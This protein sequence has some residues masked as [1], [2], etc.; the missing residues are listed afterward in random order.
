MSTE[1][2]A[3][4]VRKSFDQQGVTKTL[5]LEIDSLSSGE[6]VLS[7]P[8]NEA[9]TQQHGF[10]HAG[11]V[12]TGL[13]NACGFAAFSQMPAESEVLTVEFKTNLIAPAKGERFLFKA[14]TVK[15]G[16]TLSFVEAKAF[17]VNEGEE[18]LIAT[19]SATMIAVSQSR[20]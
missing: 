13:D 14:E 18:K 2:F 15:T 10:L 20:V 19:M 3:E 7:M 17:A 4:K 11:I 5:G 6:I 12:T 9:F 1:N 16:R 8:F